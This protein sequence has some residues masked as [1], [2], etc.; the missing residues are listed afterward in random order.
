M[1]ASQF[2]MSL[3]MVLMLGQAALVNA[4][5]A[6]ARNIGASTVA[7][8]QTVNINKADAETLAR[9]LVGVGRSRAEAIVRYRDEFGPFYSAEE[10]T[11]VKGIGMS[12]IIKNQDKIVVE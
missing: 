4:G 6:V 5:E 2:F 12:T 9:E 11:A 7:E 8:V 10:L 1:R 3:V